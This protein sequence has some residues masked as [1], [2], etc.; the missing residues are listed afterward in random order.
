MKIVNE[1]EIARWAKIQQADDKILLQAVIGN[2]LGILLGIQHA[3]ERLAVALEKRR[4]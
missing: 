2:A 4:A 1:K 3:L